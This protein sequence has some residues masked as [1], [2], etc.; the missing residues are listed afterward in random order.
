MEANTK[1]KNFIQPILVKWSN[2][3]LGIPPLIKTNKATNNKN[4]TDTIKESSIP[5]ERESDNSK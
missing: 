4:L 2:L 3:Y 1:L 5:L